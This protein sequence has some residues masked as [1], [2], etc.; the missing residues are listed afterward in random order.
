MFVQSVQNTY[1][2]NNIILHNVDLEWKVMVI[3]SGD[4]RF[5]K[6][7]CDG[8]VTVVLDALD[9]LLCRSTLL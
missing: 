6:P 1:E 8:E 2:E 7:N 9:Y 4:K 5:Q 3:E